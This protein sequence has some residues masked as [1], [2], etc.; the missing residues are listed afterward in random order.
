MDLLEDRRVDT[1]EGDDDEHQC[2][3]SI[4]PLQALHPKAC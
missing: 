1:D 2:H 3:G 4:D